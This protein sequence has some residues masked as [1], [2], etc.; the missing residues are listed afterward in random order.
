[1]ANVGRPFPSA[2]VT[3]F[4][5]LCG[6]ISLVLLTA[7]IVVTPP[8]WAQQAAPSGARTISNVATMQ[9][10]QG[11][12]Q[13]TLSSNRVDVVV[14]AV[15]LSLSL[16]AYRFADNS[17]SQ[18][19]AVAAPLC[20]TATGPQA[21]TLS[22]AWS[23]QSL[24]P[25]A[26]LSVSEIRPG[27]P[28][29]FRVD[30]QANNLNP[31][32][33]DTIEVAIDASSGDHELLTVYETG[34]STGQFSGFVQTSR[35][36]PR[37]AAGDC[38][39]AVKAGDMIEISSLA[40]DERT[41][42]ARTELRVLADP[43]G[44]VFDSADGAV[45]DGVR[46]TL[47][48][49]A[50]G[51]PAEV[52]GDDGAS[53]YPSTVTTGGT[54]TDSGGTSYTLA[55]GQ[56]RFPLATAGS[57]R[58][59]VE[60]PEGYFAPSVRSPAELA[61]LRQPDGLPFALET[62]GSY[63]GDFLLSGPEPVQISLPLDK[64]GAAIVLTK[65]VSSAVAEPGTA[66]RYRITV[67][68]PDAR[69]PT[70]SITVVDSLPAS[71]RLRPDTVRIDDRAATIQADP[72]GHGFRLVLPP[73]AAGATAT[74]AYAV[75]VRPDA[76]PGDAVNRAQ[77]SDDRGNQSNAADAAV[78]IL[79]D[80]IAS[81]MT[82]VGRVVD[83]GC[84]AGDDSTGVAGVRVMLE[85]GSYAVTDA[86]GR[87]HF[88]GLHPGTH[89]V[90]LDD[91]SLPG[92]RVAVDCTR[93]TR[94]AGR[95]FS[96]FVEGRGGALKR[97]DFRVVSSAPRADIAR[98]A[99]ARA[100]PASDAAASGAE[101]DWL[102]G[103][104]PGI[105]WLFP[106]LDHNPR[107]PLV[108]VAIKHLPGQT[109]RLFAEG[110]PVDPVAFEGSR[111]DSAGAVSVSVWRGIPVEGRST[112]LTAEV[113]DANGTRVETLS[114]VVRYGAAPVHAEL[115]PQQSVLI[116]DGI[117]RP[118]LAVRLTDRD[119]RPVRHGV[120]GDFELP[121][122]FYP[123]V[124]ADAQQARQLAGLERAR[125]FW[126]IDGEN[127]VAYIELEPTTASGSVSLRFKF[128]D[129][130]TEREQRLETWLEPG[131][132]PWTIVGLAEGTLGFNRLQGKV[133]SLDRD[134]DTVLAD[135]RVALYAKGRVRGKW[136]MTLAFDSDKEEDET[137]F[138]GVIDP[139]AYYT[140][141]ADRSERRY[142]AASVRRLYLKLERPQFYALF[143][144][145]E[146][147]ID[148]PELARYVRS[149]NGAKAEYRN[150]RL[151]ALAFAADTPTRHRR[152]EIQGNGLSGPYVLGVRD[153][154]ANS[155]RISLEV[156][157]RLRS[158]LIVERRLLV[159]HIDY[160]IDYLA[161]TLR[162]REPI[163][164]RDS[165]LNPQFILADY[166]VDGVGGRELNAGGRLTWSSTD[167]RLQVAATAIRDADDTRQSTL[168]GA[169]VRFRPNPAT[170]VRAEAALSDS[171]GGGGGATTATAWQVEAEHHDGAID[172]LAYVRERQSGFGLG[173]T[174]A[175]EDGIRK[176][177]FDAS[178]R[179]DERWN[180]S[181]SAWLDDYLASDAR[182]VAA[183]M[184][185]EYRGPTYAVRAG[186]TFADDR[187][188][189]GR[190]AR[191]TILQLGATKHLFDNRLELDAQTELPLGN[192]ESIDFPARH[193]LAARYA[194]TSAVA[195]VGTYEIADGETID[196]R[197]ARL[198]FDV[199]PW[200]GARIALSG[201]FQNIAEY[202]PRTF[203]AFGLS[204]SLVLDTHWSVDVT[205]D[206]N[207]TVGGIDPVRVLNPQHPVAS[208]GF[209]GTGDLIEDFTAA[210]TGA[211]YR[212]GDWSVTGRAEYRAGERDDRY[213]LTAAALRQIG[214]GSAL[215]ASLD[216]FSAKAAG[217][218]ETRA[219]SVQVS[220]AH[221]PA[222][223]RWQWLEK[224][225]LR[226]DQV[227][228]ATAG[229]PGPLGASFGLT[230]DARSRR[231][232]NSLSIN[233]AES[234][235][236]GR[237]GYELSLF[238]GSRYASEKLES[239]DVAGWS[240]ALGADFRFDLA[241]TVDI[242]VTGTVRHGAGARALSW[243][244]GP[245]VGFTP[246]EN[247][248]ISAGWNL[249]GFRDRDFEEARYTRGGPYVQVRFKFDQLS[250][251]G[252]GLGDR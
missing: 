11:A 85:D 139:D 29:I 211:T 105:A 66:L 210:T 145:Y 9:W 144:D 58:L 14:E 108:R 200:A 166:E 36:P 193:R 45:L 152:D 4:T 124:E 51:Q 174:T 7:L 81:K 126:R 77:A 169:D 19:F 215:G 186:L 92:D 109:V 110:H 181:A 37:G 214:E 137:R 177:G 226:E 238:W 83:G 248:W 106:E 165:R 235:R 239:Y 43:F 157:D 49:A 17:A 98:G 22:P 167:D 149:F 135:G 175:A 93:N 133:E 122:P 65:Q 218:A 161:G 10:D 178:A 168:V 26:A 123:A 117:T 142:D 112:T 129:D 184:L 147:G 62:Q 236:L 104:A 34:L 44:Y 180:L 18:H 6:T 91:M 155:E 173:Q 163:L 41:A 190:E 249:L 187:L 225:E 130:R 69:R 196:A 199:Q 198:G 97:V 16:T 23:L 20:A 33:I 71:L 46:V 150:D 234:S 151:S 140:V 208:G 185:A 28:F 251:R 24:A 162:F 72:S 171:H 35:S 56:F 222:S 158:D 86:D 80:V 121:A 212:N 213:G 132:R 223:S 146:T 79:R 55:A 100:A 195:L 189:D 232:V 63:G 39:L 228:G 153:I 111:T 221:R 143:G 160:D 60:P 202:G 31:Q 87:Y 229:Q 243:S 101:R 207:K 57:Y 237:R 188:A 90:Q 182:R 99:P 136:L 227:T 204:Q 27:E 241:A 245:S 89:V 209:T 220:W 138:A 128:R 12:G 13:S 38:R 197:T 103:Q 141:Y 84:E 42:T 75:E 191:S 172:V 219:T 107:A 242:G 233:L 119:G 116:A 32:A 170:E 247:S 64:P 114:R 102:T 67:R 125:P 30:S 53:H 192:S 250:F 25:A 154:L 246:V 115:L 15:P 74:I 95:A 203:A 96:R 61:S 5:R 244:A 230:G 59:V 50:T 148:E 82:V 48:D 8:A 176:V 156:R 231:V 159:R 120:T 206:T 217:G 1:V 240:N 94:S 118:V 179:F 68:N 216:W 73:L 131:Q 113:R 3:L 47:V 205:L 78:R 252:L 70:G 224:L 194:V 134:D 76:S 88:E 164:S 52:F 127:G 2:N 183:R 201:N 54:V 40:P 21:V